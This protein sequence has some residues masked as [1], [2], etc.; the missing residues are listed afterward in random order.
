[1]AISHFLSRK[2][3]GVIVH[4][5]SVAGQVPF[6]P[7]PV[8][9]ATKHALNGFVRSLAQLETPPA[10][11]G[12][13][14]IRVVAVAPAMIKTPL[15][16]DSEDKMKLTGKDTPWVT[17]EAVADVMVNLVE[18]EEHVGGTILEVGLKIREV[19]VFND[20]GPPRYNFAA[21]N[22]NYDEDMWAALK[23]Q[24]DGQ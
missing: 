14:K 19:D 9:V 6:F 23:K 22:S 7:T 3:P 5:S 13:P 20:P 18:K 1:M 17:P 15:W 16:T 2:K 4:I 21:P 12:L 24:F 11:T 8:Y 10:D